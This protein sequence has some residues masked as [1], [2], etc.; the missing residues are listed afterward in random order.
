MAQLPSHTHAGPL[1][2]HTVGAHGHTAR[3]A[4]IVG[5]NLAN[6]TSRAVGTGDGV[7]SGYFQDI[8]VTVDNAGAMGTDQQG[9][10]ATSATGS[11]T[12]HP[13]VQPTM[14]VNKLIKR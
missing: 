3:G 10:G 12:A 13:N 6:G 5:N 7:N 2:A 11:G 9:N 14:A 4:G 1:H 8:S